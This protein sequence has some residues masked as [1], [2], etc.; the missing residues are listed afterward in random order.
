M[1][2]LERVH[3]SIQHVGGHPPVEGRNLAR[4]DELAELQRRLRDAVQEE[5]YEA[6][7]GLRDKI[8]K[9]EQRRGHSAAGD[10]AAG[11]STAG[12]STAGGADA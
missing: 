1:P 4:A 7:A 12:D 3:D 8:Q 2:V 6:A 9:L 10:S 5:D 11:D